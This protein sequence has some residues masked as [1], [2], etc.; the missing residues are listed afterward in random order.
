MSSIQIFQTET[1]RPRTVESKGRPMSGKE[2]RQR[3]AERIQ[4]AASRILE[5]EE[6]LE[7]EEPVEYEQ[8][9]Q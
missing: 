7:V 4:S 1:I 9:E 3:R 5:T 8:F 6:A 2:A